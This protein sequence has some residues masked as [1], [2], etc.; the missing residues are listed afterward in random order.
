M[1]NILK[2]INKDIY[3]GCGLCADLCPTKTLKICLKSG[4][5][6]IFLDNTKCIECN[7]CINYCMFSEDNFLT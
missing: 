3:F 7:K 2:I 6:K 4:F 5:Y 1:Q